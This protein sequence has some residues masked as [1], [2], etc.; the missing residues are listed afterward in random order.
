MGIGCRVLAGDSVRFL[1]RSTTSRKSRA[2]SGG[3]GGLKPRRGVCAAVALKKE[4]QP[5]LD[6]GLVQKPRLN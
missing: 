1:S 3:S 6:G 4:R 5:K 2:K